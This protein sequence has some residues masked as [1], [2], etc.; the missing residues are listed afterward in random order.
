MTQSQIKKY[1]RTHHI[2]GSKLQPGDEDLSQVPLSS[3]HDH[4]LVI[5]EKLDGANAGVSF[6][7][8]GSLLLQSRGHFLTGGARERHF[9]MFKTWAATHQSVLF[10]IL[11]DRYVMY[12]EWLY[13]KHTIYYDQLPHWFLEF[14]ILDRQSDTFLSTPSRMRLLANSPVR[15]VPVLHT[16]TVNSIDELRAWI[17]PSLYKS[18]RWREHLRDAAESRGLNTDR[19]SRQTDPEDLSE[20]LYIKHED[21]TGV[22]GRYKFIRPSFLQS[23]S[24]SDGHW[25]NRPILPNRL[26][27]NVDILT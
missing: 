7:R 5:E 16:G 25:L 18:S 9:A 12:G 17:R 22:R 19:V 20:G 11:R 2:A 24:D 13:A 10:S 26:A 21:E 14:D 27:A 6:T 8:D 1:P 3:L 15:S 23:V 4:H